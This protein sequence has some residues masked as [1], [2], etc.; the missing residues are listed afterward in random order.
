M[1]GSEIEFHLFSD[2]YEEAHEKGYRG[3]ARTAPFL[4]DY[5]ILQT[6]RDEY[7][8][9]AIRRGLEAAGVPVEFS[10]GEAGPR[11]ARDQPRLRDAIEMADRNTVYKTAAKEIAGLEG[12]GRQLHGEVGHGETGSSCHIH[13]SLWSL[14]G[15]S[16]LFATRADDMPDIF[17]HWVAG[18]IAT[19]REFSL[20]WAPTLNSYKRFQPGSWA[21]TGIGWGRDN[22]TLGFRTVGHGK[23]SPRRVPDP[24]QRRQQLLRVRRHHRGGLYGIRNEIPLAPP[25]EGN[26]YTA[27]DIERIPSTM[28]Q[29]IE[30]WR[31]SRI[32]R[33][34]FRR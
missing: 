29:A 24:R 27:S 19:A 34:C 3:C 25:Y 6:T 23:G 22:R 16:A 11:P 32:A 5:Q 1:I 15:A 12:P 18:L 9:G 17:R 26:G 31:G 8:I 2:T 7:V 10:K 4:Q 14:D 33:E 30:L 21:P 20:L 13:S 28:P